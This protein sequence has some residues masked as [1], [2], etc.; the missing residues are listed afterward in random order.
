[1]D[2]IARH[3]GMS[4][5]TIYQYFSDKNQMVIILINNRLRA[6]EIQME[7]NTHE[8]TNSVEEVWKC[9]LRNHQKIRHKKRPP[10]GTAFFY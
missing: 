1:M 3:L 9:G 2:D 6:E 8:S 7:K 10:F 4:K 5:K